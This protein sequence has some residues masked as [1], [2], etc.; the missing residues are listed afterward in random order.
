MEKHYFIFVSS[1]ESVGLQ[2]TVSGVIVRKFYLHDQ[3]NVVLVRGSVGVV[4]NHH[5]RATDI[6]TLRFPVG[7]ILFRIAPIFIN[8]AAQPAMRLRVV[9]TIHDGL[10]RRL[11]HVV[12]DLGL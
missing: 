3:A 2:L 8:P 6:A 4:D 7:P 10:R 9:F 11:G 12:V 5:V 1:D